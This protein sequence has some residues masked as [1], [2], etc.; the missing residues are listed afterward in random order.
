MKNLASDIIELLNFIRPKNDK[1]LKDKV[2]TSHK[3][4]LMEFKP[5]GIEYLKN[6]ANGYVSYYRGANPLI[7]AG[8][9]E[10]GEIPDGL[11]FSKLVRCKMGKFQL[12][13]YLKM[14][15][16]TDDSLNKKSEAVANFVFPG[17][18]SDRTNIMGYFGNEGMSIIKGQ[19]KNY[20]EILL[21]K[22]N[23][24]FFNGKEKDLAELLYDSE[25]IQNISGTILKIEHLKLF[26]TKFYEALVNLNKLVIGQ[27]G[28]K[29]AFIYS[30]LIKVGIELFQEIAL[31]NGFL[32]YNNEG[33]YSIKHNTIC[34]YCG[35]IFKDHEKQ[36]DQHQFY[37]STFIT[38]TGK[39][40]D[41]MDAIPEYKK[42]I[43]DTVFNNIDNKEGR[44]LK[45][46]FGSRI[47]TEGVN[48]ENIGE[49]H[50]LDVHHNLGKV[51]QVIG[52]AIR[53]CKHYKS[54]T[55]T[56]KFPTVSIYK[57]AVRLDEGLSTEEELY[58]KAEL[59]YLLVK[60]VERALKEVAIDCPLNYN[61]N[62]FP[63]ERD[64]YK[65]CKEPDIINQNNNLN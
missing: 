27:K 52:R 48:M 6:M 7:F 62:V 53:Q 50:I 16:E 18:T 24:K 47:M 63:E 32:E 45:C 51:H 38:I 17:L 49:V 65:N 4:H 56:N 42:K 26:S 23:D 8:R 57:Y 12:D 54:I 14:K 13:T 46:V 2:F 58:R 44:Y 5:S 10:I 60:K 30:N 36:E 29:T 41:G 15:R 39:S 31:Q 34:Y 40:D 22:I 55:D 21:R 25:K 35:K 59:K 37:P 28:P 20:P 33:N 64:E 9:D 11:I 3:V 61:S 43:L 1:I 19:L